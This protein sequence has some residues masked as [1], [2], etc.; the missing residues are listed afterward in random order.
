VYYL[1]RKLGGW[2]SHGL[3]IFAPEAMAEYER[4]IK[5]PAAIHAMCEDYRAAATIDLAHD[6]ADLDQRIR[7]PLLALWGERGLMHR[8][9]DVAATWRERADNVTGRALECGHYLAEERPEETAR[10]L[11][12][13]F[14]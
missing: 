14:S 11:L 6:E 5:D 1:R 4:C 13:F 3:E 10:E 9:F 7:C 8:H 2:G 12:A